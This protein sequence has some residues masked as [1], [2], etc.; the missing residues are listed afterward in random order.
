MKNFLYK[1]LQVNQNEDS[2]IAWVSRILRDM[3]PGLRILDA[4]SGEQRYR[5]YCS[6][7]NY[8]SQDFCQYD[9]IGDGKGLHSGRWDYGR[10]DIVSDINEIPEASES[11]DAIL[12]TEVLEHVSDP[13]SALDEFCRLLRPGGLL[14]LTAPFAS[15]V[16]F[17]PYFFSTGFSRYWY[18]HHLGKRGFE[19][20]E[21]SANGDWFDVL[22]Q[23][24]MRFP[25]LCRRYKVY[26]LY[27]LYPIAVVM[28]AGLLLKRVVVG[29]SASADV[30][31]F[32]YHCFARKK[33]APESI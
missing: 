19:I 13:L 26:W 8:V 32:G 10:T 9:G 17:A 3:P 25:S 12:C 2:R 27:A 5:K 24:T 33:Q 6:Q 21:I 11:F 15:M 16:H 20:L 28:L 1:L 4:G 7:L 30:M 22:R 31:C 23:E 29:Q 14:I 18:E